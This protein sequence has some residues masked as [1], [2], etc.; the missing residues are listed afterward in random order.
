MRFNYYS[1][2]VG[3]CKETFNGGNH[4]RWWVQNGTEANSS[5]IFMAASR[6]LPLSTNH[7]IDTD[8]YNL[9]RDELVGNAT[10]ATEWEGN[11]YNTTVTWIPAGILLNATTDGINHP[12]VALPGQPAQDGR[13]AVLTITQLEGSAANAALRGV[14][15]GVG[16]SML[17]AAAA[18]VV[19]MAVALQ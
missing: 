12:E 6:E 5:A 2:Y 18:V 17:V 13:V 4:F 19:A 11:K 3:T 10:G 15:P 7:M 16:A 9:G 14:T 8:G 1:P